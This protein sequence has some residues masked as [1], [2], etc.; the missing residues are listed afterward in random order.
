MYAGVI[1][2]AAHI[3]L[4]RGLAIA[5]VHPELNLRKPVYEAGEDRG[6]LHLGTPNRN[7]RCQ[8]I[9]QPTEHTEAETQFTCSPSAC[10]AI[11]KIRDG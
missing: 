6:S 11:M 1:A 10:S 5:A 2:S 4:R 8:S 3:A 9:R 7:S